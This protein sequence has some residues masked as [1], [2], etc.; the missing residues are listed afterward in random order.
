M[1]AMSALLR[2]ALT[3]VLFAAAFSRGWADRID[4]SDTE[5]AWIQEHP[6]VHFGYD[7]GWGPFSYTDA[8]G[9]FAGIDADI[10]KLIGERLGLTF[11][12]V[13]SRS[14]PEA[15]EA[16][17]TGT[18]DFLVSTAEE[19]GRERDFIFTRAYNSFPM[20]FVTRS[21]SPAVMSMEELRG[22][23][24]AIVE[25]Y[26]AAAVLARDHPEIKRVTVKSME[27][28]FLAVAA[29]RADV[30]ATNIANANYMIKSLGVTNVKIAGVAPYLFELRYAVRKDEPV[31]RDLLD[32]GVASLSAKDRQDIVGPW[33]G[34]DYVR[35]VRWDYVMRWVLGG[36]ALAALLIAIMVWHNRR[37]RAELDVRARIQRELEATQRRLEELNEEK[38][39]MMHMAAHDLRNPLGSLMLN[40]D[41]LKEEAAPGVREQ[42]E[43]MTGLVHQMIHMIR[44]LLDVQALEDGRRRLRI[45][46]VEVEAEVEEVLASMEVQA[47]RKR[48]GLSRQFAAS[49]SVAMADRAALRQVLNNLVSNAIKYSPHGRMVTVEIGP[50]AAGKIAL[51]VRDEGPGISPD[52]M[53]RLFQ[54]YVCLSARPTGGE[55][56]TGLGLAIVKQLVTAMGGTVRCESETGAGAVFIV[57][58]PAA[59]TAVV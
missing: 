22:R 58:L 24:I 47:A 35:I 27:D 32:K 56:S 8:D 4:L 19:V 54:K 17:R 9:A 36:V 31:L 16:G 45:E 30:V 41:I 6:V 50:G 2:L 38:S 18:V 10:L 51:R 48:I 13:H 52:E 25:G 14:W 44:N 21:E 53:P 39:G 59:E 1:R 34:V 26:V 40:I 29:G 20:A 23:R 5:R 33:V 12:P 42:L 46:P 57:E 49:A 55:Q 43:R 15:Y 7:P 3:A 28:A 11:K 37:L